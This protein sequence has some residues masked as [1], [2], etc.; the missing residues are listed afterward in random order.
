[1]DKWDVKIQLMPKPQFLQFV[2]L[3]IYILNTKNTSLV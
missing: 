3:N 1:M 2:L